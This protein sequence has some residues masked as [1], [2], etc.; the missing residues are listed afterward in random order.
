VNSTFDVALSFRR[1]INIACEKYLALE[2]HLSSSTS[3]SYDHD[4]HDAYG[5]AVIIALRGVL[6]M[7]RGQFHKFTPWFLG[8]LA[9][10]ILCDDIDVRSFVCDIYLKH[11]NPLIASP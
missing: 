11:V 4:Q 3:E 10:L 8:V 5:T 1:M 6:N 7:D 2:E 9:K